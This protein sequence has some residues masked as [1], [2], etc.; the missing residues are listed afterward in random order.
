MNHV[1]SRD[2]VELLLSYEASCNSADDK[3]SSPLHLASWA[4]HYKIVDVLL[5]Q[6]PSIANVNL[7]VRINLLLRSL[8]ATLSRCYAH[9]LL[10][11]LV[12]TRTRCL[13]HSLLLALAATRTCCY[14]H[15]LLRALV[16][17][18]YKN[19]TENHF[20]SFQ[21]CGE[22]LQKTAGYFKLLIFLQGC[23]TEK[24][25]FSPPKSCYRFIKP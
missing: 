24:N 14:A 5:T 3:G 9:S 16:K 1:L 25:G 15:S 21:R 12:V 7:T 6:G 19:K 18:F 11:A 2:I 23:C 17:D 20:S 8:A 4:G 22:S 13:A 10:R